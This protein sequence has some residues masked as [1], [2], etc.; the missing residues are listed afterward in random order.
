MESR[1]SR[2][3]G[4]EQGLGSAQVLLFPIT[5]PGHSPSQP[6]AA[7]PCILHGEAFITAFH[8]NRFLINSSNGFISRRS[9]P[10]K[11]NFISMQN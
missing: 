5:S 10:K 6:V 7:A 9:F 8:C 1:W 2:A 3:E 11:L 4:A